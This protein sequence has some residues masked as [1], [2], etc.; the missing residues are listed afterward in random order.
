MPCQNPLAR[1]PFRVCRPANVRLL[2]RV[3]SERH[4]WSDDARLGALRT[5]LS[6]VRP[7]PAP[8][9]D[10]EAAVALLVRP[11][12]DLDVL[13]IRRAHHDQDPW[14]GHVALPGGRRDP[15]DG[16]LAATARRETLEEVGLDL[17][18]IG[19][20]LGRLEAVIPASRRLPSLS[21][22]PYVFAVEPGHELTLAPA[23]VDA[24]VWVPLAALRDERA[25]GEILIEIEGG[26][27][28]FPALTYEDYVVWGLT[29]RVLH[30]F[31]DVVRAA[32]L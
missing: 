31:L 18:R 5:A 30:H 10:L 1:L 24:A 12:S 20:S 25:A 21:I 7:A 3:S 8:P 23:E 13:L 28:R 27:H 16:D 11:G 17:D 26:S 6:A 9:R 19:M 22:T 15:D 2:C 29:L 14:S 32:H 4:A